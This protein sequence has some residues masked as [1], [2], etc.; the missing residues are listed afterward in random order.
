LL[1]REVGFADRLRPVERLGVSESG[2]VDFTSFWESGSTAEL[3]WRESI[4]DE[5]ISV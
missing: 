3:K 2:F 1:E 5:K 4:E